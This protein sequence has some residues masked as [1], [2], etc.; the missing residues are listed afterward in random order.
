MQRNLIQ[1]ARWAVV[2]LLFI[3]PDIVCAQTWSP[4]RDPTNIA[5]SKARSEGRLA[6][7]EK[8]LRDAI[9]EFKQDESNGEQL[10]LYLKHLANL[11]MLKTNYTEA[12]TLTQRALEI[13]REVFG[14]DSSRV[15]GDLNNLAVIYSAQ[16][17]NEE[18]EQFTKQALEVTRR[19]PKPDARRTLSMLNNLTFFYLRARRW[20]EAEPLILEGMKLCESLSEP[21]ATPCSPLRLW[22]AQVYRGEGKM[23]EADQLVSEA[24]LQAQ[25]ASKNDTQ[26]LEGLMS[27]AYKYE[28]EKNYSQAAATINQA[29]AWIEKHEEIDD[30]ID[31][32]SVLDKLGQVL[33]KQGRK[34]EAEKVYLR[35]IDV[36][37]NA[38]SAKRPDLPTTSGAFGLCN[39]YR[40][41]GR[42]R[43]MEPIFSRILATQER[44]LGPR[45]TDVAS[46]MLALAEVYSDQEKFFEARPLFERALAIQEKNMGPD[47]PHL[48]RALGSYA[49]VLR[50]TK[51][52]EMAAGIESR[53]ETIR[54]KSQRQD[55]P[56]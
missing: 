54:K 46:T 19:N 24:D 56:Q 33:E 52:D 48:M 51:E 27:L 44:L 15:A 23:K 34:T 13:D 40:T 35:A 32:P 16:G 41:Q 47:H 21:Q 36:E 28:K 5:V 11:L 45:H 43:E 2:A 20:T 18:A 53:I 7:A 30:P 50:K 3:S 1:A 31:L 25:T 29:I 14:P 39:L 37:L 10:S 55:Q 38:A 9:G 17:R 26:A 6:D 4:M 49:A 42:L 12:V 22:L 8:I